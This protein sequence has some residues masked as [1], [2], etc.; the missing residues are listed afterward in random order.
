MRELADLVARA[1]AT[2]GLQPD[3]SRREATRQYKRLAKRWH[4]DQYANDPQGQAEASRQMRAINVAFATIQRP[5]NPIVTV[6]ASVRDATRV[7]T[8]TFPDSRSCYFGQRLTDAELDEIVKSLDTPSLAGSLARYLVYGL[9]L[10]WGFILIL[11][12]GRP[13]TTPNTATGVILWIAIAVHWTH[14]LWWRKR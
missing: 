3:C 4:P 13:H 6:D 5:P 9:V 10:S 14:G 11:Q 1:Y 2:L 12:P 7:D 8:G